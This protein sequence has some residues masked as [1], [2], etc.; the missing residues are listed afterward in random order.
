MTQKGQEQLMRDIQQEREEN[1]G[2]SGK[3]IF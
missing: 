3:D 2:L 1:F